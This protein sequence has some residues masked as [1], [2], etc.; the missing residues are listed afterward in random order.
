MSVHV[1]TNDLQTLRRAALELCTPA[2]RV[3]YGDL[4]RLAVARVAHELRID[5]T[6][7]SRALDDSMRRATAIAGGRP[8]AEL[9]LDAKLEEIERG[10][11]ATHAA[12]IAEAELEHDPGYRAG[13]R[14][15]KAST[16]SSRRRAGKKAGRR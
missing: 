2:R 8:V 7:V 1:A 10:S 4:V 15:A 13:K 6:T 9:E 5:P 3:V 14:A 16:S 12:A 11:P